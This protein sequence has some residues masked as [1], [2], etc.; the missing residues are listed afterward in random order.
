MT[1]PV[2]FIANISPGTGVKAQNDRK[3]VN[4]FAKL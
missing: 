4:A 2:K 3:K 1:I